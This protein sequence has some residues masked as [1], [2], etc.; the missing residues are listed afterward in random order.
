MRRPVRTPAL[1]CSLTADDQRSGVPRSLGGGRG[2]LPSRSMP[3]GAVLLETHEAFLDHLPS[4]GHPERP[5]RLSAV[6]AGIEAAG[7]GDALVAVAPRPATRVELERVHSAAY[8]DSVAAFCQRGGGW[9]DMDTAVSPG[10]WPAAVLAAGA[11]P[12]AIERLDRGEADAAFVA[13]RPP[14]HHALAARAMGFCLINNVAVTAA[15]LAA[16]GERVLVVDWDA[17]HGNGTQAIFYQDPRVLYVSMHQYPFY[18]GTGGLEETGAG[19]GVGYTINFPFP[20]GATGDVYRS[21]VDEVV[22][23]AAESFRP[24]WLIVSAGFD[25]HRSDPLTEL[26]LAAGDFADLTDALSALVPAGHRMAIL[27]GGYDLEALAHS[28][29]ACVARLAGLEYRPEPST[30]GGPGA[31]VVA[32][33][34]QLRRSAQGDK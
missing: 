33:A 21:A 24:T 15:T 22:I 7:M 16:R 28:A 10:S 12:D 13:V 29:G 4:G 3:G 2:D 14:G 31:G 25:A 26:G 8:L 32:Q 19:D 11:G 6:L 23:P 34:G 5:A 18:P 30:S 1:G 20:A 9:L 17:H 27:E